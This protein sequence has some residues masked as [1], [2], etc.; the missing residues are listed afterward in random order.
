MS[1]TIVFSPGRTMFALLAPG[2][3]LVL[4]YAATAERPAVLWT[5]AGHSEIVLTVAENPAGDRLVSSSLDGTV[6]VWDAAGNM[7]YSINHH[8]PAALSPDGQRF[9]VSVSGTDVR[10]LLDGSLVRQ[11]GSGNAFCAPA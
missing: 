4:P 2:L 5:R 3:T 11:L 7:L 1:R 10:N 9:A 8:G 6:K